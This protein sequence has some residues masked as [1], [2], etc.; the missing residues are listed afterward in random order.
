MP[1]PPQGSHAVLEAVAADAAA[2]AAGRLQ[3]ECVAFFTLA[4]GTCRGVVLMLH[5]Y[6]A[7]PWQFSELAPA[8]SEA[9][10][11]V[12]AARLPGHGLLAQGRESAAGLPRAAKAGDYGVGADRAFVQAR[13]LSRAAEV[14]LFLFGFSLGGAMSLDLALR[15]PQEVQRLIL[16]APLLRPEGV[17][18]Q[19]TF[20]LLHAL[21]FAGMPWLMD[22][23]RISWGPLPEPPPG[24]WRRPGH[25]YFSLGNL[26][27]ALAYGAGV[28]R[29]A[30]GAS[31]GMPMPMQVLLTAN[32]QRCDAQ[33]ALQLLQRS[34]TPERAWMFPRDSGVPHAMLTA[35]E[36]PDI[37]SRARIT[38]VTLEFLLLRVPGTASQI[39]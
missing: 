28:Q 22:R 31:G 12:Y 24:N 32:D 9:G 27:A 2:V 21:R 13:A 8:L 5:G 33:S 14:P 39:S 3:P 25:W 4:V 20:A 15:Y 16:A 35:G 34:P 10:M 38:Q 1:Q 19:R 37:A 29:L 36:N 17:W 23:I 30:L 26:Y 6:T 18:P 11:H 7:G